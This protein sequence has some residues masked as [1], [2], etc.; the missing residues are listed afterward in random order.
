MIHKLCIIIKKIIKGMGF[1]NFPRFY[2][3]FTHVL[4]QYVVFRDF[5]RLKCLIGQTRH[6]AVHTAFF[7]IRWKNENHVENKIFQLSPIFRKFP[8]VLPQNLAFCNPKWI[9]FLICLRKHPTVHDALTMHYLEGKI[10]K[11]MGFSNFPRFLHKN[12][13][14][15]LK[16]TNFRTSDFSAKMSQ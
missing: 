9:T 3:Y 5:F 10:S 8:Y 13:I 4:P 1:S 11:E 12:C 14:F 6:G 7:N 2:F 16:T 15:A